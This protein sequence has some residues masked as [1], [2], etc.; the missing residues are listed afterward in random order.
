M[1]LA[2]SVADAHA[3]GA[4]KVSLTMVEELPPQTSSVSIAAWRAQR[5]STATKIVLAREFRSWVAAAVGQPIG[6]SH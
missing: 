5:V 6:I 3:S 4:F 1:R 2:I